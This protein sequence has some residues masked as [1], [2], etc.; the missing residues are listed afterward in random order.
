MG[1]NVEDLVFTR[2]KHDWLRVDEL[3]NCI[4]Y[5]ECPKLQLLIMQ[6][7]WPDSEA[8]TKTSP[9][10]CLHIIACIPRSWLSA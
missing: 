9:C 6:L 4:H 2:Y 7:C 1:R 8:L 3:E 5:T 10:S